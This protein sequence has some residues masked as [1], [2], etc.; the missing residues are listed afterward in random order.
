MYFSSTSHACSIS[1]TVGP[2]YCMLMIYTCVWRSL[3]LLKLPSNFYLCGAKT[4]SK[5]VKK[6][7]A[8]L[9]GTRLKHKKASFNEQSPETG[10]FEITSFQLMC[11]GISITQTVGCLRL[12]L[13]GT[14]EMV[15]GLLLVVCWRIAGYVYLS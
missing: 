13:H 1:Y 2:I 12:K 10:R 11:S 4:N 14:P 7:T 5:V 8:P 3:F 15:V 6:R 9:F